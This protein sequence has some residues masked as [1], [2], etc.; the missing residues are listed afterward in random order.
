MFKE[1]RLKKR[2]MTKE[3]TVEVLKIVNLVLFPLY[4]KMVILMELL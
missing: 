3:D 4:L 1:M 2:E